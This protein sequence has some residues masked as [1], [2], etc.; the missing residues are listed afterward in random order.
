[1]NRRNSSEAKARIFNLAGGTP[2]AIALP[3]II[4]ENQ[5]L[6]VIRVGMRAFVVN[7]VLGIEGRCNRLE[8][9]GRLREG[10]TIGKI[11]RGG[12]GVAK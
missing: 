11:I 5:L 2:A 3:E 8:R 9:E 1:M 10:E 7:K 6:V 4:F 12:I